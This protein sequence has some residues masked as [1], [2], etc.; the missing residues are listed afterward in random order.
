MSK[1]PIPKCRAV[2][3]WIEQKRFCRRTKSI[4]NHVKERKYR[5]YIKKMPRDYLKMP[6]MSTASFHG[7]SVG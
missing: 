1:G 5:D 6:Q 3:F 7:F 2:D 4:M